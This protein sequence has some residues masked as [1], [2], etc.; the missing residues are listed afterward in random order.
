MTENKLCALLG[1]KPDEPFKRAGKTNVFRVHDGKIET[2][3]AKKEWIRINPVIDDIL[4]MVQDPAQVE[5][6]EPA[7]KLTGNAIEICR[8]LGA[9]WISRNPENVFCC[10]R[11][12]F[13]REKPV[14]SVICSS[15]CGIEDTYPLCEVNA[16]ELPEIKYGALI[17][18]SKYLDEE[19]GV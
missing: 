13:W 2:H 11:V 14:K 5:K 6:I 19:A 16:K 9:K 7:F 18:V 12:S 3:F 15:F 17:D 1:V 4:E 10:D 8:L